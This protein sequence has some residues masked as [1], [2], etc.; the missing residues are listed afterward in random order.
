MALLITEIER[1]IEEDLGAD[2]TSCSIVPDNWVHARIMAKEDGVLAGLEE[3][4]A[5]FDYFA[6]ES[7][8]ALND[9][10][11]IKASDVVCELWGSAPDVL[12]CERLALNF[13]CKMSG[14]ATLTAQCV[15]RAGKTRIACTRKTTPG[16]RKFEKK[17]VGLGGGDTHRFNLSDAVMIKDNHIAIMGIGGAIRQARDKASF[18]KKIEVEVTDAAGMLEAA[19][20]GAD[21][22]MFDNMRPEEIVQCIRTLEDENLR[23]GVILEAS[24][25]IGPGNVGEYAES[26]VDVISMGSLIH[27]ARWLDMS[28]GIM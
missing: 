19:K 3:A 23:G 25:G 9:G 14:I 8:T 16:F 15:E 1:Y 28:M 26:G 2:D 12:R 18:T 5:V 11:A 27:S 22:I 21:I 20:A 13:L 4:L 7:E 24:G 17:A 10:D 6:L